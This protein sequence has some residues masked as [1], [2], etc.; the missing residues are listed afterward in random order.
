MLYMQRG[1][2]VFGLQQP[3]KDS[4]N[5]WGGVGGIRWPFLCCHSKKHKRER[6]DLE[7]A[8]KNECVSG[9]EARL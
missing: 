5:S 3:K 1:A 2:N 7:T 6:N 4:T 9:L 8:V